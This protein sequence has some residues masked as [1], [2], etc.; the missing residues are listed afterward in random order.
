MPVLLTRSFFLTLHCSK[1]RKDEYLRHQSWW[2]RR[3]K[4]RKLRA[5]AFR[6]GL[7]TATVVYRQNRTVCAAPLHKVMHQ[8]LCFCTW[9]GSKS[10]SLMESVLLL[11]HMVLIPMS[12]CTPGWFLK[13]T[14]ESI[15]NRGPCLH[16]FVYVFTHVRVDISLLYQFSHGWTVC[17][18]VLTLEW[19][20]LRAWRGRVHHMARIWNYEDTMSQLND[21]SLRPLKSVRLGCLG[22][23]RHIKN[24]A[25]EKCH[26]PT[27][28]LLI[29][30]HP[31]TPCACRK[32]E[33]KEV[34]C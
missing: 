33:K 7:L 10:S 11:L 16:Y 1:Y 9:N 25:L 6:H 29:L 26:L 20:L 12:D 8:R 24:F 31:V 32:E 21:Y 3:T 17:I 2:G 19:V 18:W 5:E 28:T 4:R 23:S 14:S 15:A 27:L 30:P 22:F 34:M 13:A